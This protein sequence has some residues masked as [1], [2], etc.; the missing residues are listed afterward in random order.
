MCLKTEILSVL[1]NSRIPLCIEEVTR[2]VT[3]KH[4]CRVGAILRGM[5]EASEVYEMGD[6][7]PRYL[8]TLRG[9]TKY[10]LKTKPD[11]HEDIRS[12][13]AYMKFKELGTKESFCVI[14]TKSEVRSLRDAIRSHTRRTHKIIEVVPRGE[15]TY[16][17]IRL[18]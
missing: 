2:K 3:T 8:L 5:T 18:V 15:S 14:C 16:K 17:V 9:V 11:A 6:V 4:E 7:P 10:G 1:E 13:E 12:F